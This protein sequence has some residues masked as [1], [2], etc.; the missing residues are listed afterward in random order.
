MTETLA[1]PQ[2]DPVE[3][4]ALP[5]RAHL[6]ERITKKLLE[7]QAKDKS[8]D[9][10]AVRPIASAAVIGILRPETIQVPAYRDDERTVADIPIIQIRLTERTTPAENRRVA[11]LLFRAMPRPS[12]L[13]LV[14]AVGSPVLHVALTHVSRT[15]P[16]RSTSVIDAEVSID[17]ADVPEGALRLDGLDR[18]NL[19]TLYQ[20]L[21]RRAVGVTRPD[22]TAEEAVGAH[23][24]LATLQ[25]E[26]DAVVREAKREKGANARIKLNVRAKA[27]RAEIASVNEMRR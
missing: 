10:K 7:K 18:T 9:A 3:I 24:K 2:L 25:A 21:V 22:L 23:D 14:P 4:L 15:D 27:L 6:Q 20:D 1:D 19:W 8:L 16:E 26:L 11:E 5:A 12:V 17:L 13:I